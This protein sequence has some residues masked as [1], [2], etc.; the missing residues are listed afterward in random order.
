M[1]DFL[2]QQY[3]DV[4][5]R[6]FDFVVIG[7]GATGAALTR[8]MA[9]RA[10]S[11]RILV[12]DQ[13]SFLLPGHV[14]NHGSAYQPLMDTAVAAPWRTE[15]DL[16]LVGQVP[17]L[18]GRTLFWSGAAPTPDL[19]RFVHWPAD[20]VDDLRTDL[21]AARHLVGARRASEVAEEFGTLNEQLRDRILGN[22]DDVPGM[23]VPPNGEDLDAP[24][25][26]PL[27]GRGR[28]PV[29]YSA[30]P[31]LLE[32]SRAHPTTIAV[33]PGCPVHRLEHRRG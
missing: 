30:V 24:L 9:T 18:G 5:D 19:D 12:L 26:M 29:K 4:A 3:Q 27:T 20:V 15:G 22:A 25:G 7:A 11:A 23:V 1:A 21:R 33:V 32:A 14:Q 13:G 2:F 10:P 16:E 8:E 17:Y 28:I 31:V 6:E